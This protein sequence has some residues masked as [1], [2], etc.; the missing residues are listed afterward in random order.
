MM[1]FGAHNQ[2]KKR[3]KRLALY[4]CVAMNVQSVHIQ[5]VY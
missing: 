5:L 3:G 1:H 4:Q 2:G